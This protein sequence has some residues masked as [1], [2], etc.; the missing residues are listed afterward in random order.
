MLLIQDGSDPYPFHLQG[1]SQHRL[2][3]CG[4]DAVPPDL[5]HFI[6][7]AGDDDRTV[8]ADLRNVPRADIPVQMHRCGQLRQADISPEIRR[9]IAEVSL[10]PP[11][12]RLSFVVQDADLGFLPAEPAD[13]C[14][15]IFPVDEEGRDVEAGFRLAVAAEKLHPVA[16]NPLCRF[17]SD[18]DLRQRGRDP[19]QPFQHGRDDEKGREPVFL[20]AGRQSVRIPDDRHRDHGQGL[21]VIEKRRDDEHGSRRGQRRDQRKSAVDHGPVPAVMHADAHVQRAVFLHHALGLS[22]CPGGIDE[23]G[24]VVR[25]GL[26]MPVQRGAAHD[27]PQLLRVDL[28][29]AARILPDVGHSLGLAVRC[30]HHGRRTGAPDADQRDDRV[31]PPRDR[32]HHRAF[33][34]DAVLFQKPVNTAG[35]FPKLGIAHPFPGFRRDQGDRLRVIFCV[36]LQFFNE[37]KIL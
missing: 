7:P 15:V 35:V 24:K 6:G 31:D 29:D 19:F 3:L 30:E 1:L 25:C 33:F 26:L 27:L 18:D 23:I 28:H 5:D 32:D 14:D 10:F 36:Y 8:R 21:Q 13:G 11:G 22:R 20:D 4:L 2:D 37:T 16:E 17:P 12:E 34:S 9:P